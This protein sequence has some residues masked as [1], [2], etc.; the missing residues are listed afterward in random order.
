VGSKRHNARVARLVSL[1]TPNVAKARAG[2]GEALVE[3]QSAD[4]SARLGQGPPNETSS[5]WG[6]RHRNTRLTKRESP[7]IEHPENKG[8][9]R[10]SSTQ[11]AK[12]KGPES[13][14]IRELGLL[15][16]HC[17]IPEPRLHGENGD[18]VRH[19][20]EAVTSKRPLTVSE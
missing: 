10:H 18:V 6:P 3:R 12:E 8:V 19:L 2:Y 4:L 16:P 17:L 5:K 7:Y 14:V 9:L 11:P 13:R 1:P 15:L 20:L